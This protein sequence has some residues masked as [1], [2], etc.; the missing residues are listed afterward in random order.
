MEEEHAAQ[1]EHKTRGDHHAD[2]IVRIG[3]LE[4]LE[5]YVHAMSHEAE[6]CDQT[7]ESRMEDEVKKVLVVVE[8]H[9]VADPGTVMVHSENTSATNRAMVGTW[10][11]H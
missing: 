7:A 6:G 9:A 11:S 1:G 4:L 10:W 3:S 2:H 8:G 5:A